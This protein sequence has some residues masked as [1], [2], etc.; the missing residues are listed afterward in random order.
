MGKSLSRRDFLKIT[1]ISTSAF[2]LSACGIDIRESRETE[3]G[4][5]YSLLLSEHPENPLG[6]PILIRN[7]TSS[8]GSIS[9]EF[10]FRDAP[11]LQKDTLQNYLDIN[12][13]AK[14]LNVAL[15]LDVPYEYVDGKSVWM[16]YEDGKWIWLSNDK[17][18]PNSI[19]LSTFSSIGFNKRLNQALV[20]MEY[21]CGGECA[22]N[23]TYFL[24]RDGDVWN[25]QYV[26]Q[27][28]VS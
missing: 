19:T 10:A 21:Y 4:K 18:Y 11:T 2:F 14:S 15:L 17:S 6:L 5:I 7:K 25:L 12:R 16:S 1:A 28:W 8:G 3:E 26:F 27:G 23:N 20:D 24:I 22:G 9:K 13:E